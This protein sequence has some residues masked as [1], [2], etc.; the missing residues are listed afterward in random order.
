M[1]AACSPL[2]LLLAALPL[3]VLVDHC[4]GH[5]R[6]Q[7]RKTSRTREQRPTEAQGEMQSSTALCGLPRH[8][9]PPPAPPSWHWLGAFR[10][11]PQSAISS[12]QGLI[13]SMAPGQPVA[14]ERGQPRT[15]AYAAG[16]RHDLRLL[17]VADEA[18]LDELLAGG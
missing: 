11:A 4:L 2:F 9:S 17:E 6:L 1:P 7:C 10:Q 8:A 3:L 16:I 18:M 13:A 12:P 14:L 15:L 5:C